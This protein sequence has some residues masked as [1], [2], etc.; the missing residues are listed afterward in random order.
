MITETTKLVTTFMT[1][2]N[3][4][5]H[6]SYKDVDTSL[7]AEEIKDIC[8]LMT[9]LDLFE[10]DGVKLFDSVVSAKFV[11]RRE[12]PIFDNSLEE[13]LPTE[14]PASI[15]YAHVNYVGTV[16]NSGGLPTNSTEAIS[17][18]DLSTKERQNHTRAI[19]MSEELPTFMVASSQLPARLPQATRKKNLSKTEESHPA[20]NKMDSHSIPDNQVK[21]DQKKDWRLKRLFTRVWGNHGKD[22]E[23]SS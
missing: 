3:E 15:S 12:I 9:S 2:E 18:A 19:T 1:S 11:H 14:N 7:S 13:E 17:V 6:W 21:G 8:E 5:H 16:G 22:N 20:S 4:K 10:K 23:D